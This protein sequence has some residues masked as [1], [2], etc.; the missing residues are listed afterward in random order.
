MP[1]SAQD[2]SPAAYVK[3]LAEHVQQWDGNTTDVFHSGAAGGRIN[4]VP[5]PDGPFGGE[6]LFSKPKRAL[7]EL[8]NHVFSPA[9][10]ATSSCCQ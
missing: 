7:Y 10:A 3:A 2:S 6:Q 1:I 4:V 5:P 9:A 8:M